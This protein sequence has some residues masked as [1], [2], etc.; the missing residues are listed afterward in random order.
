[1]GFHEA[2]HALDDIAFIASHPPPVFSVAEGVTIEDF[3]AADRA[4]QAACG[5][6]WR[7]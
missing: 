7:T 6:T 4:W 1:M 3:N 2:S 5:S